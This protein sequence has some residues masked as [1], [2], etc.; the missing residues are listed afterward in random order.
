VGGLV[1][2]QQGER[3]LP[4]VAIRRRAQHQGESIVGDAG[5]RQRRGLAGVKP[6]PDEQRPDGGQAAQ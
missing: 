2:Q 5:R 3:A 1:P 6:G 4:F